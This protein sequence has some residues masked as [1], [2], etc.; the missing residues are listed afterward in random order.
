MVRQGDAPAPEELRCVS[1]VREYR[2]D[3]FADVGVSRPPKV[4]YRLRSHIVR[5]VQEHRVDYGP[6][7]RFP[8]FGLAGGV[9]MARDE[10]RVP[11]TRQRKRVLPA[12]VD[13]F[14]TL[15]RAD[16]RNAPSNLS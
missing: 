14:A 8:P 9:F 16:S 10:P 13:T 12:E 5:G 1:T 2:P 15:R 3:A 4:A 6:Q 11:L 7:L